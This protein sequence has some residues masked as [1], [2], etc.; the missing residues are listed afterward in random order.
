MH[1]Q[2]ISIHGSKMLCTRKR[3]KRTN[4]RT[5]KPEAMCLPPFFKVGGITNC[6]HP[7]DRRPYV[8]SGEKCSSGFREDDV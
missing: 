5:D 7:F 3:D 2:N 4:E 1:F 6:Q 8:K